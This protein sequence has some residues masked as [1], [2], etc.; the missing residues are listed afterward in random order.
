MELKLK[1]NPRPELKAELD[2]IIIEISQIEASLTGLQLEK[3]NI[4]GAK[5]ELAGEQRK[6]LESKEE[7]LKNKAELEGQHKDLLSQKEKV[8]AGISQLDEASTLLDISQ[9]KLDQEIANLELKKWNMKKD[10]LSWKVV[11]GKSTKEKHS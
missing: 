2:N 6:L 7:S 5:D 1:D 3:N 4:I 10:L 8:L 11:A 9:K